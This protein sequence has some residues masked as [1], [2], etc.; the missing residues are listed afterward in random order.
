MRDFS[1]QVGADEWRVEF[2]PAD[3]LEER[4]G[5]TLPDK[6]TILIYAHADHDGDPVELFGTI[7]HELIHARN[8]RLSEKATYETEAAIVEVARRIFA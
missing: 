3:E 7:V 4:M 8:K 5:A 6:Q 2:R 1:V